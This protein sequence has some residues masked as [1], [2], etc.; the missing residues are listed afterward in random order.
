VDQ[1]K[2]KTLSI[3]AEANTTKVS[4]SGIEHKFRNQIGFIP[5]VVFLMEERFRLWVTHLLGGDALYSCSRLG[6]GSSMVSGRYSGIQSLTLTQSWVVSGCRNV[7]QRQPHHAA[8]GVRWWRVLSTK[9]GEI[10][11]LLPELHLSSTL[12]SDTTGPTRRQHTS[13]D[14]LIRGLGIIDIKDT[15]LLLKFLHKLYNHEN[16][17]WVQITWQCLYR[18]SLV[19]HVKQRVGSFWWKY[20]ISLSGDF[21]KIASCRINK[22]NTVCFWTNL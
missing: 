17:S 6:G 7:P 15:A 18:T 4:S 22:G 12:V 21:L 10:F 14:L 5:S 3:I 20:V 13:P 9:Y 2:P 1:K 8:R 19:P 11:P 16:P